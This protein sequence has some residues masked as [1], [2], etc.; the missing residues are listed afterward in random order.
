[1]NLNTVVKFLAHK[2]VG[3]ILKILEEELK[4]SKTPTTWIPK[5]NFI[6]NLKNPFK[7]GLI[8]GPD[9]PEVCSFDSES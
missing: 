1:M 4:C 7:I 5:A 2:Q 6:A 8:M 9:S 3:K